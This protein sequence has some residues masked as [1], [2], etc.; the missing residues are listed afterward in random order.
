M[1]WNRRRWEEGGGSQLRV[2]NEFDFSI[3]SHRQ[4]AI[5]QFEISP[6]H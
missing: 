4:A 1:P 2:S 6:D 5:I 3:D